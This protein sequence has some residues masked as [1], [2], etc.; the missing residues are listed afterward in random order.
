LF[1]SHFVRTLVPGL[2]NKEAKQ[3]K[4]MEKQLTELEVRI[5]GSLIEKEICT[6]DYYPMTLNALTYACNQKNN[7]DPVVAYDETT[8][9]RGLDDLREK[10]YVAMVTGAGMRVPKYRQKFTEAYEFTAPQIAVI[11]TLLLRGPQTVGEIRSRGSVLYNFASL[12]EVELILTGFIDRTPEPMVIRLPRQ[13]GQKEQRYMHLFCG[14]PTQEQL[15]VQAPAEH[16]R[17]Q[18]LAENE[19]ITALEGS[20]KTLQ[21]QV[22]QLQEQFAQFKKQFE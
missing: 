10:V 2:F 5:I 13:T 19:R 22:Q 1:P 16:A 12:D 3:A 6:P 11:G 14:T 21:E 18:V 15:I 17:I 8:V 4:Y 7:R 20:V 9:V